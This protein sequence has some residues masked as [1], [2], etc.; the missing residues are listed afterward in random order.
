MNYRKRFIKTKRKFLINGL[1]IHEDKRESAF[2]IVLTTHISPKRFDAFLN[3][4]RLVVG[5][6]FNMDITHKNII[7]KLI[8]E[9]E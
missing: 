6:E 9:L 1:I 2:S 7:M 3:D 8:Q 5:Q 4:L